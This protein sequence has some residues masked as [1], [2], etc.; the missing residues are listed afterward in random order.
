MSV[1]SVVWGIS[2]K[3]LLLL[4]ETRNQLA[5]QW[6]G[7]ATTCTGQR[8]TNQGP[9]LAAESW[10]PSRTADIGDPLLTQVLNQACSLS[11]L[12]ISTFSQGFMISWGPPILSFPRTKLLSC[13]GLDQPTSVVVDPQLGHM[14]WADAGAVPKIES[15]WLDGSK[16]RPLV[17]DRVRNELYGLLMPVKYYLYLIL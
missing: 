7:W 16:R 8:P 17:L 14:F 1:L 13:T 5:S 4:Q 15:A 9:S 10:W 6:I 12:C 3:L 2:M 11:V